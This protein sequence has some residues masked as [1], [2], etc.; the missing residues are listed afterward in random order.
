MAQT[1]ILKR[2]GLAG[3]VPGTGSLNLGEVAINTFDGKVFFKR[4]GSVESIQEILTTNSTITGSLTMS[5]T[6]SFASLKVN[7]T[8]TVN[9]GTTII[10]GSQ[11]VTD[12]LTVLG[13]INARQFNISVVSSSV[14][15][16]S[17]S[18]KFGDTS[19]DIHSF[20]GSLG[21]TGSLIVTGSIISTVSTLWSGSA[22]L[23]SGVVSGSAQTITHLPS[24]VVSGSVQIDVMSTTNI[25]RIAT[26]GS[27][28]FQ[29]N[30]TIDGSLVVTGSVNITNS[31]IATSFVGDG[32][33]LTGLT[34][35]LDLPIGIKPVDG[36]TLVDES[37]RDIFV[38]IAINGGFDVDFNT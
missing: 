1:I 26:T 13:A 8:L 17:G 12:E 22:Q 18:T 35:N 38:Q 11:L 23:P 37:L 31:V 29:S 19:D 5:G 6:G 7:D 32:S 15:Y 3:K 9:H 30:Q 20:T 2:S 25:A 28:T 21:V 4:S 34:T 10:S 16:Q 27:N 33:G 14:I 24:G 36:N